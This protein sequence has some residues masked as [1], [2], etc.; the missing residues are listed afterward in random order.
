MSLPPQRRQL[1]VGASVA[2]VGCGD[3]AP[4]SEAPPPPIAKEVLLP[5]TLGAT[6]AKISGV[7]LGGYHI[8]IP[9][10]NESIRIIR[11]AVDRG[12]TFLDNCWDYHGGRSEERMGKALQDGYRRRAFLMT[13]ID[14]RTA[15]SAAEQL[16]QSLKRLKTDT[17]DLVQIH[18]VIRANDPERCFSEGCVEALVRAREA[19]K[20]HY[21]GFTGH[22]DPDIHLAM[23]D[24]AHARGFR[25]DAVQMPLNVFDHHYKSFEK[26]VLP[27][28]TRQGIAV[29]GMKCM[30]GGDILKSGVVSAEE[31]LRYA[32]SLPTSVVI[33]GCESMANL[34][35]A[36]RV[37]RDFKPL[38]EAE[39]AALLERSKPASDGGRFEEFK[40]GT[41]YDGTVQN[42]H[43]LDTAEV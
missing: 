8:G 2:V 10:E 32:L 1:L 19:G 18:E 43:W 16:H 5:R 41:K 38:E 15:K 20:I 27:E 34:D 28:L 24:A 6:K 22:K 9:D 13:K 26:K 33:T 14:G 17:I 30:G 11:S 3:K 29:L 7:G 23:L 42:P 25:F 39:M 31:C 4:T 21:I 40:S 12:I 36:V 37:A 35:Q